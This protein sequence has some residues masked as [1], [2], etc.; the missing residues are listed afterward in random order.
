MPSTKRQVNPFEK[1]ADSL[2]EDINEPITIKKA[3]SDRNTNVS[4]L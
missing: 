1:I 3:W 2:F 4:N